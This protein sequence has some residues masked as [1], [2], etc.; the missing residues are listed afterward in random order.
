MPME[1]LEPANMGRIP[2]GIITH[3]SNAH[4]TP[5]INPAPGLVARWEKNRLKASPKR[6]PSNTPCASEVVSSALR[7]AP[8]AAPRLSPSRGSIQTQLATP[9]PA[10]AR[11]EDSDAAMIKT[12][13]AG[14]LPQINGLDN[15]SWEEKL[16]G[17]VHQH[18]DFPL[19]TWKFRQID[20]APHQPGEQARKM[21]GSATS[22]GYGQL[23]AGRLVADNA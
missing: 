7:R 13:T 9:G 17:P 6:L 20:T 18:P 10:W 22:K 2:A 21:H 8:P 14:L 23:G 5:Q 15:I 11:I 4:A 12:P 16:D 1:R 19:Y 3:R